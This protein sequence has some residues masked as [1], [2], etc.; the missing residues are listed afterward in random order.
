V[1][2]IVLAAAFVVALLPATA[3]SASRADDVGRARARGNRRPVA[4]A[5]A[6]ALLR[7]VR[8]AQIVLV[9]VDGIGPHDV[10]GIVV[11]GVKFHHPLDATE[12]SGEITGIVRA[13][14]AVSPVEEVDV[15][16]TIPLRLGEK[17]VVS[18]DKAEAT[19]RIVYAATVRRDAP[20]GVAAALRD[21]YWE[22]AWKAGLDASRRTQSERVSE[23]RPR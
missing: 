6:T 4:I 10:A 7:D 11:S 2:R 1:R 19:T 16:A 8:P 18:G 17:A 14:F 23:V 22:P 20:R 9:R 15:W 5:L 3:A 13:T 12:F 21:A